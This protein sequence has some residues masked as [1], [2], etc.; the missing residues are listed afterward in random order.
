MK[1]KVG[2]IIQHRVNKNLIVKI[3]TLD[4]KIN[5]ALIKIQYNYK[6]FSKEY[7]YAIPINDIEAQFMLCK[8]KQS[9]AP[10]WL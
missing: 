1:F 7:E 6:D 8:S 10:A 2:D 3:I 4:N 9:K 5:L